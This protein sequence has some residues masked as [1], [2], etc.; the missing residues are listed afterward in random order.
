MTTFHKI[1]EIR[2]DG[3]AITHCDKFMQ[4]EAR[5]TAGWVWKKEY[6]MCSVCKAE[7]KK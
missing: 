1:V 7:V 2:E 5:I 4:P 3:V 6:Y